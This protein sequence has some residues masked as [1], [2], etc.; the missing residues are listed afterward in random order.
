ML[1]G[2]SSLLNL[3]ARLADA[4]QFCLDDCRRGRLQTG[5]QRNSP[6]QS[7]ARNF[8]SNWPRRTAR[9]CSPRTWA[10]TISARC[11]LRER[12]QREIRM[13]RAP[14]SDEQTAQHLDRFARTRGRGRGQSRLQHLEHGAA[15]RVAER[16]PRRAKL[17]PSR[18]I[19]RSPH[20]S[21]RA[22]RL[23]GRCPAT[24]RAV[25]ARACRAGADF[26]SL[27]RAQLHFTITKSSRTRRSIAAAPSAIVSRDRRGDAEAWSPHLENVI[28]AHWSQWFSLV[29]IFPDDE[30][31]RPRPIG[32]AFALP[33]LVAR[34]A[35]R[36]VR[37]A[38]FSRGEAYGAGHSGLRDELRLRR[39]RVFF[40][41]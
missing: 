17:S 27:H 26:S 32:Y 19:A 30:R 37:R 41:R 13:V 28:A 35:G 33:R 24:G 38:E 23:F 20:V 21:Q 8:S 39:P 14:E 6:T 3:R 29:P 9:F 18:A 36:E 25:H 15:A 2:S 11:F 34:L 40:L 22:T 7:K 12:Y 10:I 4:L 5:P 1:P 16:H 31:S